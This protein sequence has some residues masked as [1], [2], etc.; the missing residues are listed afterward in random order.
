MVG[1]VGEEEQEPVMNVLASTPAS[2]GSVNQ[3]SERVV[4]V[5][6]PNEVGSQ[7]PAPEHNS[8]LQNSPLY[9]TMVS[10]FA[11]IAIFILI[12]VLFYIFNVNTEPRPVDHRFPVDRR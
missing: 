1:T 10:L 4:P 2:Y 3:P 5:V 12:R 11:L 7:P 9:N 6:P 8:D